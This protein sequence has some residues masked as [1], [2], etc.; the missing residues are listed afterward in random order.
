VFDDPRSFT[1]DA[2][3]SVLERPARSAAGATTPGEQ[4]HRTAAKVA[5]HIVIVG[6]GAGGLVL[7]TRLGDT[8]GR[9]GTARITLIDASLTHMWKPLL[10]E[11]AAGTQRP[12]LDRLDY[13][14]HARA[15]HFAFQLGRMGGID[16]AER[17]VILSPVTD[18]TGT[19]LVPARRL[20]YDTLIIAVG[21]VA[22]DFGVPGVQ[23]HCLYLDSQVQAE[24]IQRRI[25]STFLGGHATPEATS[26]HQLRFAIIGA[27]ATGVELA[28]ELR[29]TARRV[30]RYGITALDPDRDVEIVL[31]EAA[32]TI[33][34]PLPERVQKAAE[35]E[36]RKL[37]VEIHTAEQVC[38]VTAE[39]VRTRSGLSIPANLTVWTAGVKGPDFLRDL[40]GL[41][42]NRVNQLVVDRS[43]KVTRD[44]YIFALGDCAQCPQPGSDRPV[45][46]RAQAAH[47]QANLLAKSLSQRL[48]GKEPLPFVYKDYGSLVSLST[49]TVGNLM[50]NLFRNVMLEGR[51]ARLAYPFALSEA[52]VGAA[53]AALGHAD[54]DWQ[55]RPAVHQA[56]FQA[57]LTSGSAKLE[58]ICRT[59]HA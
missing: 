53:R 33:L 56:A 49:S 46:P 23:E 17:E 3:T 43:L 42:V 2:S 44:D 45:P 52:P 9:R 14:V 4:S 8:L 30:V 59:P 55:P 16:R 26:T 25:L 13:F 29:Q 54:G 12:G 47:Q 34:P 36:L 38:E 11:V 37:G 28:A 31:L 40:D 10:H 35:R 21:S 50:G 24:R 6:G 1:S 48:E 58:M 15:H 41:E 22:N 39:G 5:P 51:L 57:P 18:E 19:E 7:A 32:P 20:A 27:G